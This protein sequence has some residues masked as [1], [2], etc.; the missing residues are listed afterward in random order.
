MAEKWAGIKVTGAE[1]ICV[2]LNVDGSERTVV[3]D[4]TIPIQNGPRPEAYN[5]VYGRIEDFLRQKGINKAALIG[6]AVNHTGKS[7]SNL[8]AA[9]LRGV[10]MAAAIQ[11]ETTVRIVNM[12]TIKKKK[13]I[14]GPDVTN[15]YMDDDDVWA[16]AVSGTLRKGSRDAG[17]AAIAAQLGAA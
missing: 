11:A 2:V 12:A 9:E 14:L 8:D 6:S 15:K 10:V 5:H 16:K 7:S 3:Q 1:I 4:V 13:D 17:I